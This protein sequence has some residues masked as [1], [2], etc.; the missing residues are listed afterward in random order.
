MPEIEELLKGREQELASIADAAATGQREKVVDGVASLAVGLATGN[1]LL[2]ALAPLARKGIAR[3][4]GNSADEMFRRELAAMEKDEERQKFLSQIDDVVAALVGQALIQLVRNQHAVKDEVLTA[5]GGLR[6]DFEL[7]RD[8]FRR[9]V[10]EQSEP[11]AMSDDLGDVR[12]RES[13]TRS[14]KSKFMAGARQDLRELL[15]L[16]EDTATPFRAQNQRMRELVATMKQRPEIQ[17]QLEFEKFFVRYHAEMNALEKFE[18]DQ[19]RA[20]TEGI[21]YPRNAAALAVLDRSP[22]LVELVPELSRL[23]D[24]LVFWCNKYQKVFVS[25]PQ[26]CVVYVGV[27]DRVPFPTGVEGSIRSWL[28]GCA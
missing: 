18:F 16:L 11:V 4:L 8:D 25:T 1:P 9:R 14:V 6:S 23:R 13:T 28:E 2:A 7:F 26:M 22:H 15:R 3:A 5:L 21:L 12:I 17:E 24:H 19:L 27:E 20:T 10:T